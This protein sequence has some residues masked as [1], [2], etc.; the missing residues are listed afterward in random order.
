MKIEVL[1]DYRILDG[2][3]NDSFW[4]DDLV[5]RIKINKRTFDIKAVG[6]IELVNKDGE[7]VHN[8]LKEYNNCPNIENDDDLRRLE[9]KGFIWEHNNW[10]EIFELTKDSMETYPTDVFYDL[11]EL[12][13][14]INYLKIEGLR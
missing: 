10:F 6:D 9:E 2:K 5:Y 1:A 3:H 7:I 14:N 11:S 13:D 8:G 4:Y 12:E